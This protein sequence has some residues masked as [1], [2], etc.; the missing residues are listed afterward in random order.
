MAT[1]IPCDHLQGAPMIA[2]DST[3]PVVVVIVI[4]VMP[5]HHTQIRALISLLVTPTSAGAKPTATSP[6]SHFRELI[7]PR[8]YVALG[9]RL[10][11]V[12]ECCRWQL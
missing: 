2:F 9:V 11:F 3:I 6:S 7:S 5:L 1:A 4:V 12:D 8:L 10:P